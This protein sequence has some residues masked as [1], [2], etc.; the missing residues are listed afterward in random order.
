MNFL[1]TI[2]PPPL[3]HT[4]PLIETQN[5]DDCKCIRFDVHDN[6]LHDVC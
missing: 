6:A 2:L 5:L 3:P 1:E 4:I